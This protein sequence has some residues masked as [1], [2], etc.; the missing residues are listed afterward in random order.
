MNKQDSNNN[1]NSNNHDVQTSEIIKSLHQEIITKDAMI[2]HL[3]LELKKS[4]KIDNIPHPHSN[5]VETIICQTTVNDQNV[6]AKYPILSD[7]YN[8]TV[9]KTKKYDDKSYQL[10][11]DIR[12]MCPKVHEMLVKELNFPSEYMLN[13]KFNTKFSELLSNY[14]DMS[15]VKD[16]I[17]NWK[18]NND[19]KHK[20]D[21]VIGVDAL[22]FHPLVTITNKSEI[23]GMQLPKEE[24]QKIPKNIFE[25]FKKD[26]KLFELFIDENSSFVNRC[27]FVFQIQPLLAKFPTF[28]VH[29][30][31]TVNGS[32]NDQIIDLLFQIKKISKRLNIRI[33][34]FSFDGDPAYIK[35]HQQFYNSYIKG[36][37][38]QLKQNIF[39]LFDFDRH[40]NCFRV[41]I[42]PLH[43]FKRLRYRLF[44][45]IIHSGFSIKNPIIDMTK[46]KSILKHLPSVIFS[47]DE[48]TKMHDL[49]PLMLFSVHNFRMLYDNHQYAAVAYW[50]P[51]TCALIGFENQSLSKECRSFLFRCSFCF[52]V[53]YKNIKDKELKKKDFLRET[54]Y[55]SQV[56]TQ[57]YTSALL[58]EFTNLMFCN[59]NLMDIIQNL[60]LDRNS[61]QPLEHLFGLVRIRCEYINTFKAF[62]TKLSQL[63]SLK[64]D[65]ISDAVK[66][67]RSSFGVEVSEYHCDYF[68]DD[69]SLDVDEFPPEEIA[70]D[71][72]KF[73]SFKENDG[74][75]LNALGWFLELIE[76]FDNVETRKTQSI[77][78]RSLE[79]TVQ[80]GFRANHLI[81]GQKS[82]SHNEKT[83][84]QYFTIRFK[85]EL[86]RRP[87]KRDFVYITSTIKKMFKDK[88]EIPNKKDL[89]E[90]YI[91]WFN[92]HYFEY[93]N[94]IN[95]LIKTCKSLI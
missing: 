71:V 52:L 76:Y 12:T 50:F 44:E 58:M 5:P 4:K 51:I 72:L 54:K 78:S 3:Q 91:K 29:L 84:Y 15:K 26:P 93:E 67:R 27:A 47:N 20:I 66:G 56:D 60:Y 82:Y 9:N 31:E 75:P 73:A 28:V 89:L 14:S 23:F 88:I 62:R 70:D 32:A 17:I 21:A 77:N 37:I 35:L 34:S 40:F 61:T 59:I 25:L 8:N 16:I 87:F 55:G 74:L 65:T 11:S 6:K 80:Q 86:S 13:T 38:K 57:F 22:Y 33:R 92:R 36:F 41:T 69:C 68:D 79:C 18:R 24:E 42:D 39:N 48:I 90:I 81:T 85:I 7:I 45:C 43:L 63:Q 30:K 46:L 53:K 49:L 2:H 95:E 83:P 94:E 19:I 64:L 1:S 10:S